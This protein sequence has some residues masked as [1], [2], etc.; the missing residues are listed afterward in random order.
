MAATE[1]RHR[2]KATTTG[3]TRDVALA[4]KLALIAHGLADGARRLAVEAAATASS[5]IRTTA[6]SG[7]ATEGLAI[8]RAVRLVALLGAARTGTA[9]STFGRTFPTTRR[10]IPTAT[11][12]RVVATTAV[13]VV[14]TSRTTDRAS[15]TDGGLPAAGRVL[16]AVAATRLG[17]QGPTYLAAT[18]S[19]AHTCLAV[20]ARGE[21]GGIR[22]VG[23]L[24]PSRDANR[25]ATTKRTH[26]VDRL[27]GPY[28]REVA[29]Q[30]PCDPVGATEG[31]ALP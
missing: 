17:S 19:E 9:A 5:S 2:K 28:P 31:R 1:A 14:P 10:G 18:S 11:A 22:L 24:V 13:V 29:G 21:V 4:R 20:A 27:L 23:T 16:L 12:G 25:L 7:E 3:V 8:E 26:G 15:C 30:R 6:G